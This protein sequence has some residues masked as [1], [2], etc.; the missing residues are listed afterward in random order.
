VNINN[1][2][3]INVVP[4]PWYKLN[5]MSRRSAKQQA[6]GE[7]RGRGDD[8]IGTSRVNNSPHLSNQ[9]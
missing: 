3:L 7:S 2:L 1:V 8:G 9:L 4:K 6:M 5:S